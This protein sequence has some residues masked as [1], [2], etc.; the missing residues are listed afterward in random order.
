MERSAKVAA[1]CRELGDS[2]LAGL[3]REDKDLGPVYRRAEEALRSGRT[4]PGLETDLDTLDAMVLRVVGQ[5]LYPPVT[6]DYGPLPGLAKASPGALWW[7]CPRGWCAGRG[8]VR[9]G[10]PAPSCAAAGEPP[11]AGPL[12]G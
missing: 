5:G 3:A 7:T 1:F 11:A 9:P 2:T 8:R 10:Q 4:G 6:R 12:P